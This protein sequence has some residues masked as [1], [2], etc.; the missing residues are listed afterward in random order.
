MLLRRLLLPVL[1]FVFAQ[2]LHA[3]V[4]VEIGYQRRL[5]VLYEPIP[6]TVAI[7]NLTGRDLILTD[8]DTEKWFSF[9]VTTG[10]GRIVPPMD[11][12]YKIAGLRV[13]TGATVKHSVN[14]CTMYAVQDIGVYRIKASIYSQQAKQYYSSAKDELEVTEAKTFWTQTVGVPENAAVKG[15]H[16]TI[17][18]LT[19][20]QPKY[21][22]LYVRVE[23]KDSN[24]IY[25][26]TSLG[27]LIASTEPDFKLD[28]SNTLHVLQLVGA[29]TFL[30]SRVNLNGACD[31]VNYYSV[32]SQPRLKKDTEGEVYV[33]GGQ[34]DSPDASPTTASGPGASAPTG[35]KISDRP[36][37]FSPPGQ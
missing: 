33:S 4:K 31:Q 28:K 14:L 19:F 23:D 18:L 34:L 16:R 2:Q 29:R 6:I 24:T 22:V 7:T 17:S 13:P 30:Y 32:N 11:I 27:P 25:A 36:P 37:G 10:D 3:Q 35:P 21:N 5:F 1:L 9:Q 20:R 15:T 8:T 12:N 26:T